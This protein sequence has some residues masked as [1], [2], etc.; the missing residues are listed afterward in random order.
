[1]TSDNVFVATFSSVSKRYWN[2]TIENTTVAP[3]IA[4]LNLGVRLDFPDYP[5]GPVTPFE[6]KVVADSS[7]SKAGNLLGVLTRYF[8]WEAAYKFSHISGSWYSGLYRTFWTGHGRL[9]KSFFWSPSDEIAAAFCRMS[10]SASYK[11]VH[12]FST[13]LIESMD[14]KVQGIDYGV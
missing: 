1:M 3:I 2:V 13:D 5:D 14:F 6:E 11:P 10:N 9:F 8:P 7:D 4:C 12:R